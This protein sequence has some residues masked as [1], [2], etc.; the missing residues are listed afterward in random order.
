MY[1]D[2]LFFNLHLFMMMNFT[3]ELNLSNRSLMI[4]HS[5]FLILIEDV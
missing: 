3:F 1:N 5:S 2:I 4:D